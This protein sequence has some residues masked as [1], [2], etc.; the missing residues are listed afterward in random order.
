[1]EGH[2]TLLVLGEA[3]SSE[4]KGGLRSVRFVGRSRYPDSLEPL[5][6]LL[7]LSMLR[8]LNN[9]LELKEVIL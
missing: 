4:R 5:H 3:T 8:H 6:S 7:F 2:Y 9:N 1:M